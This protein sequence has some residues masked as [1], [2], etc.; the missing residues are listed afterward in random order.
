M[1]ALEDYLTSD[2]IDD[3]VED[4]IAY[5]ATIADGR[6]VEKAALARMAIHY[7]GVP[8]EFSLGSRSAFTYFH[9]P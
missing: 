8:G 4:P 1:D 2:V 6:N 9:H 7:L 5:W 3:V